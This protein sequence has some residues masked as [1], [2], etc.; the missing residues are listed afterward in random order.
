MVHQVTAD[1]IAVVAEASGTVLVGKQQKAGGVDA[2][3]G[4][5]DRPGTDG[6]RSA[7]WAIDRDAEG[8]AAGFVRDDVANVSVQPNADIA[9][10]V[11]A[12]SRDLRDVR[13][14]RR[15]VVLKHPEVLG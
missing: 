6:Q 5:H 9:R 10:G 14:L 4:Q 2:S 3:A 7:A 8:A 15:G 12:R 1:R 11:E 13:S